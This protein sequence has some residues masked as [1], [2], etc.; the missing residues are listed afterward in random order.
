M[1]SSLVGRVFAGTVVYGWV[2]DCLLFD[3]LIDCGLFRWWVG[4]LL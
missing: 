1:Y 2:W 4:V 3:S